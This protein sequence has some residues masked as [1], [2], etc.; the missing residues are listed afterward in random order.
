MKKILV[1][2]VITIS[3]FLYIN[4]SQLKAEEISP[5]AVEIAFA[6]KYFSILYHYDVQAADFAIQSQQIASKEELLNFFSRQVAFVNKTKS[7]LKQI[8]PVKR[9]INSYSTVIDG[10]NIQSEYLNNLIK[11]MR[12]GA[13]FDEAFTVGTVVNGIVGRVADCFVFGA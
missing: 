5:D 6:M 3:G 12:D 4:G 13:S 8:V 7:E 10:L 1:I 9:Y 2:L 11:S